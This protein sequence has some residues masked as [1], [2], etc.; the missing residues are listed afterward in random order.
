MVA[1]RGKKGML[2][3]FLCFRMISLLV[4]SFVMSSSQRTTLI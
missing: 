1:M 2:V 4:D 3:C